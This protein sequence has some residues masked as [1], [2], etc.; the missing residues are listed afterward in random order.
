MKPVVLI[1]FKFPPYAGVGGFRWS[2]LCK[3][4]ALQNHKIYVVTVRWKQLGPN[5]LLD[6]VSH[7][8]IEIH[9]IP[10]NY[11]HNLK[12]RVFKNAILAQVRKRFLDFLDRYLFFDDY[13]QQWGMHLIPICRGLMRRKGVYLIIATGH[14]FQSMRWAGEL[15]KADPSVKVILD[16]RDPWIHPFKKIY[17][18]GHRKK[19]E[20]WAKFSLECANHAV[21]VTKS[22]PEYVLGGVERPYSIITNGHDIEACGGERNKIDQWI[23]AGNL[24]LGR[25]AMAR[26]FLDAVRSSP[27]ALH[28]SVVK[29]YGSKP[30]FVFAEYGDLVEKGIV[31]YMGVATQE[32][33]HEELR[34][35]KVALHFGSGELPYALSTKIFEYSAAGVPTLSVSGGG[36]VD[37]LIKENKWGISVRP[38]VEEV[39]RAMEELAV[40]NEGIERGTVSQ[41]H[42]KNLA[43]QYSQLI[44][45]I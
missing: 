2:K 44:N 30:A 7:S 12:H 33:V 22:L 28:G 10:S 9:R 39:K 14:P 32:R 21:F 4:L 18:E 16:F 24:T 36:E 13:A 41:Y 45:G 6:D 5:S 11:P 35:S 8:N 31:R 1:A 19:I 34:K 26:C 42:Y 38:N 23:H 40:P 25:Q 43:H 29:L 3:Y 17:N 27:C 15:K 37:T 20:S